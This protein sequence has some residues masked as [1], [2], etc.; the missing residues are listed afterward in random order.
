MNILVTGCAGFIGSHAVEHFLKKGCKVIG[1]DLMTYSGSYD[2]MKNFLGKIDFYEGD[3]RNYSLIKKIC[4]SHQ[5]E[6]IVN[7]AAETHVDNSIKD[8]RPFLDAN[9]M[10]VETILRVCNALKIKLLHI[11]TDEV[12][13]SAKVGSFCESDKLSP[14]NPYSA[15]K[16]SAEMLIKSFENTYDT[17]NIIVRMSNNFGPRQHGEKLIPTII[18]CLKNNKKI[19]VYGDGKNIRD[20][21]YVKDAAKLIHR[22]MSEGRL[23]E[24]YNITSQNE[25]TNLRIIELICKSLSLDTKENIK[26]VKDRPGH[27]YRYSISSKKLESLGIIDSTPFP[28][29]IDETVKY[30]MEK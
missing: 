28:D 22:V 3:I 15:S 23:G 24:T 13:G 6:W 16:A 21:L 12:Y 17:E 20:W 27:D 30:Y 8:C 29:C 25:M 4:T 10:G 18:N 7:F 11:S 9:I 26:F 1:L 5:I 19:P 14:K 2:N